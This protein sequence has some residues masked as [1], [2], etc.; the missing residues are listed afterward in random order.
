GP[1][2]RPPG[3]AQTTRHAGG[4]RAS[5]EARLEAP[6]SQDVR[7]EMPIGSIAKVPRRLFGA[8]CQTV[9]PTHWATLGAICAS[10]IAEYGREMA[11]AKSCL[12]PEAAYLL[13]R[14]SIR[15]LP[16]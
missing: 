9:C 11:E 8:S 12:L 15:P 5:R 7:C 10:D 1:A 3:C 6:A 2:R 14:A 13:V 4:R 16:L